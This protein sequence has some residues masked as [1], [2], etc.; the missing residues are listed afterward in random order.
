MSSKN[1]TGSKIFEENYNSEDSLIGLC[2]NKNYLSSNSDENS[3]EKEKNSKKTNNSENNIKNNIIIP[4]IDIMK[5]NRKNIINLKTNVLIIKVLHGYEEEKWNNNFNTNCGGYYYALTNES[6]NYSKISGLIQLP[7]SIETNSGKRNAYIVYGINGKKSKINIGLINNGTGWRPFYETIGK[8]DMKVFN[9]YN[10]KENKYIRFE[11]EVTKEK[12]IKVLNIFYN[13]NNCYLGK[14]N[15]SLDASDNL[16]SEG[17]KV[18]VKFFRC[19]SLV[20]LE[21]VKDDKNDGTYISNG[22]ISELEIT[23][24][25]NI[26][27][28]GIDSDNIK[29]LI[30]MYP[31]N[32]NLK[33]K[34][35]EETFSIIHKF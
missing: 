6:S 15:F 3:S 14:L 34:G 20:P 16:E 29:C 28:W 13:S 24:N 33:Y 35:S 10:N 8:R 12:K 7:D 26:E 5:E 18:K 30:L 21:T 23:N 25:N 22:I 32:V 27:P 4:S 19:I 17:N 11:V 1:S 9:E 31:D 2:H